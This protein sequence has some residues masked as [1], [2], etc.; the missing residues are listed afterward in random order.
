M[1]VE[2]YMWKEEVPTYILTILIDDNFMLDFKYN[3]NIQ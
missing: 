1:N 3:I 2:R